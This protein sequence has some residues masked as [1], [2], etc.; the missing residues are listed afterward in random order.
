MAAPP[1]PRRPRTPSR[2]Q[3]HIINTKLYRSLKAPNV[4]MFLMISCQQRP[5]VAIIL[6]QW[7]RTTDFTVF[8][9]YYRLESIS[10]NDRSCA[11][12]Y[13]NSEIRPRVA[14]RARAGRGRGPRA[15]NRALFRSRGVPLSLIPL[16]RARGCIVIQSAA[17]PPAYRVP[18][19]VVN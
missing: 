18:S 8:N 2:F 6:N 3:S 12:N 7:V 13:E 14:R 15:V 4:H 1:A 19:A 5:A 9:K 17:A 16:G 11:L 10:I